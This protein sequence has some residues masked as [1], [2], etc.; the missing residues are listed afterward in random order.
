MRHRNEPGGKQPKAY[1]YA[2][3]VKKKQ[4]RW[5]SRKR[6]PVCNTPG[7]GPYAK[8]IHGREYLYFKHSQKYSNRVWHYLGPRDRV[9]AAGGVEAFLEKLR[10]KD[11]TAGSQQ[12]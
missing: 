11:P 10:L 12:F 9:E 5:F 1:S 2:S 3:I 4:E 7:S 8:R 6:C